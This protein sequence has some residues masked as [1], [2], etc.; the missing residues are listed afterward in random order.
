MDPHHND[1][2][3]GGVSNSTLQ[4]P[5]LTHSLLEYTLWIF[6]SA[7]YF[8]GKFV[9]LLAPVLMDQDTLRWKKL[10]LKMSKGRLLVHNRLRLRILDLVCRERK[11][12]PRR[13]SYTAL[14]HDVWG[15]LAFW[16]LDFDSGSRLVE[17]LC[18]FEDLSDGIED[19]G[20]QDEE[21]LSHA[22]IAEQDRVFAQPLNVG[23]DVG[24]IRQCLSKKVAWVV[25]RGE[26]STRLLAFEAPQLH[27]QLDVLHLVHER[28]EVLI[29]A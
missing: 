21:V 29:V 13:N 28:G 20:R 7:C 14:V 2:R 23:G 26:V 27:F 11:R 16:C 8:F 22:R 5:P 1:L 6:R 25:F 4:V 18:G 12:C 3:I 19:G 24:Q 9:D 15:R 10:R 17:P